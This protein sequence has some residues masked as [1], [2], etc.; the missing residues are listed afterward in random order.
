MSLE[1][2][3]RLV[4]LA[5]RN[6]VIV[7][8]DDAYGDICFEGE[9]PPLLKALD[10]GGYVIYLSTFSKNV[11]SG[12]RL[13][14]IAADKRIVRQF[15]AAKQ[16]MDLHSVSLSQWLA[17]RFVTSGGLDR[18][19][20]RICAEYRERRDLMLAA[21]SRYAPPGTAWDTPGGGYY[22]W[23]RLPEGPVIQ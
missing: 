13:G 7:L 9:Q 15:S 22:I 12:L 14:W 6:N 11:Y 16:L 17:E 21:L 5:A 3:R 18:H 2:R 8:E 23:C 1:R 10:G 4:S 20:T 19:L